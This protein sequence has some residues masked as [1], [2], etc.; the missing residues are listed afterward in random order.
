[1]SAPARALAAILILL[2]LIAGC[3]GG[4]PAAAGVAPRA[5]HPERF[6]DIPLA[7]GYMLA[8][9]HDQ[10]AVAMAGGV[11]R[12]FD[13]WMVAKPKQ[14]DVLRGAELLAWYEAR[15]PA[16]G[17]T[18]V[19]GGNASE[20]RFRR[21]WPEGSGEELTIAAAGSLSG[22]TVEYHLAPWTEGPAKP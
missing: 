14:A 15:L 1:M 11:V 8:P 18:A 16:L 6:P 9:G 10:L 5:Y 4:R 17:W 12:R 2:A 20:R 3:G 21:S 7:P 22:P 13:V 19:A